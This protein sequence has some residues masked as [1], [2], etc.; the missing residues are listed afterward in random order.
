MDSS[1]YLCVTIPTIKRCNLNVMKK[2]HVNHK[3][4]KIWIICTINYDS[5]MHIYTSISIE[6]GV[7][8]WLPQK[9]EHISILCF[10]QTMILILTPEGLCLVLHRCSLPE[11]CS[12]LFRVFGRI[13]RKRL[14]VCGKKSPLHWCCHWDLLSLHSEFSPLHQT[15]PKKSLHK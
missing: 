13:N 6:K 3:V 4:M 10:P 1:G 5:N 8:F 2:S 15:L 9:I 12:S 14:I 7:R 11:R